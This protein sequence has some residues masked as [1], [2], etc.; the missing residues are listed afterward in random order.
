MKNIN[1]HTPALNNYNLITRLTTL[2]ALSESML[3]GLLH[4]ARIPFRGM[5]LSSVAIIIIILI[6][7]FSNKKGEILK[8]TLLV[9]V[10]KAAVSPHTPVLAYAVIFLQ[11]LIGEIV[12]LSKSFFIFSSIL[13]GILVESLTGL[14]RVITFT[15]IFGMTLW[16]A[17][18]NFI[19][20]IV[21][22]FLFLSHEVSSFNYSLILIISYVLIHVLFG[23][24]AAIFAYRLLA[25]I[26]SY[27]SENIIVLEKYLS[28]LNFDQSSKPSNRR[29][30]RRKP[31]YILIFTI[32]IILLVLSYVNP[33]AVNLNKNS[34][35]VMLLRAVL[36]ILIWLFF[37]SPVLIKF[38]KKL[39]HQSENKYAMEINDIVNHLP[40]YKY[41][42]TVIWQSSAKHKGIHKITHFLTAL[43]MNALMLK[44]P[45]K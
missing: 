15:L 21:K 20:F 9:L 3:G 16:D 41:I 25:K 28:Q 42:A 2:W 7:N 22:E 39:L 11:G 6:A 8:A 30:H 31:V 29:R 26:N 24:A 23:I 38:I 19:S 13:L 35:L 5:V 36:V 10:I 1:S 14:H 45:E 12:F 34:L 18:N 43:I 4:A 17:V 27:E 40:F 37:L 33:E 32:L 44:L